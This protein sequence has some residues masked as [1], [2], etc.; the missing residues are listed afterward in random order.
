MAIVDVIKYDG[1]PDVF[2]WKY[3]NSEL[4][5]WTQLIVNEAQEAVLYKGGQSLDLFGA[6]RHTLETSNIPILNNLVNLPFGGKSPFAAEV[7]FINKANSLD[8]KWGTPTPIQLQDP[9]YNVFIPL[10]AYGQFGIK[11]VDSKLFLK[12]FVGTLPTFTSADV[13]KFFKGIYLTAVKDDLA[14]YLI[15]KKISLLEINAYLTDISGALKN[16]IAP[17]FSEYGIE[18]VSFYVN[19]ISV[20][21]DDI[22]VSRLKRAL[23]KKAEMDIIGYN[24]Q[25]ERSFDTLEGAATNAGSSASQIM[26][27]GLG[28][29][30]GFGMGDQIGNNF[31]SMSRSINVAQTKNCPHCNTQVAADN[32]FCPHCGKETT[33]Q[34]ATVSCSKCGKN[35]AVGVKFYSDCGNSLVKTCSKCSHVV[36]PNQKFCPNCGDSLVKKCTSCGCTLSDNLKFCPE[37]GTKVGGNANG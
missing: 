9:K 12:K 23:A 36:D 5:T 20:P 31:S 17:T 26:G 6:G 25:Q 3:P 1:S 21:D 35:N 18:L 30:M 19:D 28:M 33:V 16:Q 4:G 24:Y 27:A 22:A 29:G 37:C 10:R 7:W 2:A 8:I 11:I 15:Q 32:K 14:T 34:T 13:T